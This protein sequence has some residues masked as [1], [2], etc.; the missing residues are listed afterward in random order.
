MGF[1]PIRGALSFCQFWTVSLIS[2]AIALSAM[3]FIWM[4]HLLGQLSNL[5][6]EERL[7]RVSVTPS[8]VLLLLVALH[9]VE[10]PIAPMLLA[11]VDPVS[12]IFLVVVHVI[13][14]LLPIVVTL[15]MVVVCSR[16]LADERRAQQESTENQETLHK[17]LLSFGLVLS[18]GLFLLTSLI[19]T[20]GC[21]QRAST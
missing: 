9:R 20:P 16:D 19:V 15:V 6:L 7:I 1:A 5:N 10:L 11:Q 14:V 2:G 13:I 12:T 3:R 18:G 8:E 4:I 21:R 17:R